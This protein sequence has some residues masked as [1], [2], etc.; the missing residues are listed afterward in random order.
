MSIYLYPT[1]AA[2]FKAAWAAKAEEEEEV[3]RE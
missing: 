3:P 1:L 2:R